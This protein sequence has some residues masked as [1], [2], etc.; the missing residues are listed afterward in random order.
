M[1]KMLE[2]DGRAAGVD[3]LPNALLG[4]AGLGALQEV[5]DI[6]TDLPLKRDGESFRL[7]VRIPN[8]LRPVV[9]G[10]GMAAGL[11]VPATQRIR[12]AANRMKSSNNLKQF[13][14]GV[15]NYHDTNGNVPAAI[16]DN[17]GKP[18]LSWRVAILPYIE[19]DN[20]YKQFKLDEPWDSENNKA[21]IAQMPKIF[22][23]PGAPA[24][25]GQ[26]HYRV[27]VGKQASFK[28]YADAATIAGITDGTSNTW[29]IVEAAEA[30]T[31]TKPDE[32]EYDGKAEPKLGRF[33]NGGFN[34]A[35]WDGS[36]RWFAKVPKGVHK[37]INPADGEVIGPDDEK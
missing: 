13:A 29:M 32:L 30:V 19:Q 5:E 16:C 35:F 9:L 21:L 31:W 36:V 28:S 6:L 23:L 11:L 34:V 1:R 8:E 12:A 26:T 37:Y 18:L 17:T 7:A 24:K 27:F 20:L 14:L 2:G 15:H 3:D 10:S 25:P 22:E 33:F 4:L